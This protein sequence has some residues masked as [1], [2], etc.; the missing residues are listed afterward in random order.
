M[1]P[2]V[3]Y[4][5]LSKESKSGR[6]GIDAQK[7]AV[8]NL[9]KGQGGHLLGEFTEIESGKRTDRAELI[10]A[11]SLCR[12]QKAKL[13]IAKLDRLARNAA[14]LLTLRDSGIDFVAADLPTADKLTIGIMALFAEHERDMV[15]KRTREALAEAKKRGIRLGT[16]N[17]RLAAMA[18]A[19]VNRLKAQMYAENLLPL[20]R[21][22]Q[23]AGLRNPAQLALEL[24]R[25]GITSPRN[26][27]L[28]RQTI[29]N[30]IKRSPS[31]QIL[32]NG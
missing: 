12:K 20:V 32:K 2:F 19:R 22:L 13:C 6:L 3:A 27:A 7:F 17:P 8:E 15:S 5:R 31:P 16:P 24:N 25:R 10:A 11:L 23:E 30:I 21:D 1:Q 9:V 18:A 4:Y 14:F 29:S 28:T 26:K